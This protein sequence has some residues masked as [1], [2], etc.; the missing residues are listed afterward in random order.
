MNPVHW[1][2]KRERIGVSE[3][4]TR[5]EKE[6]AG[7]EGGRGETVGLEQGFEALLRAGDRENA[8]VLEAEPLGL[9]LQTP[10]SMK[11]RCRI[12]GSLHRSLARPGQ[13]VLYRRPRFAV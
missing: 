7:A 2:L 8:E 5:G 1:T 3:R 12:G 13:D 6:E 4:I 11:W 9:E 10:E